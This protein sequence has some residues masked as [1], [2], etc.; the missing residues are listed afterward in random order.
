MKNEII[1]TIN[2]NEKDP[3][4][5]TI[6]EEF[7]KKLIQK[8][9]CENYDII[10]DYIFDYAFKRKLPKNEIIKKMN[11][12]FNNNADFMI[13]YLWEITKKVEEDFSEESSSESDSDY[14]DYKRRTNTLNKNIKMKRTKLNK[15]ERSREN[16]RE[17]IINKFDLY[18]YSNYPPMMSRGFYPPKQ[19]YDLPDIYMRRTY[20]PY[21]IPPIMKK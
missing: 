11:H 19:K 12:I 4:Y 10:V 17:R 16:S 18:N 9:Q 15:R 2:Y 1:S 6:K 13:N 21:S 20:P 3:I 7:K 8:Y 14:S 5:N